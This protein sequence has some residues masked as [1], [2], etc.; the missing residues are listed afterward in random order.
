MSKNKLKF[1]QKDSETNLKFKNMEIEIGTITGV[2]K[3]LIFNN[4]CQEAQALGEI[5]FEINCSMYLV[6]PTYE[7]EDFN[8]IDLKDKDKDFVAIDD[9]TVSSCGTLSSPNTIYNLDSDISSTTTCIT[10]TGTNITFNGNGHTIGFASSGSSSSRGVTSAVS[11]TT[12]YNLTI[13]GL[14]TNDGDALTTSTRA[15]V[16]DVNIIGWSEVS[17]T[18]SGSYGRFENINITDGSRY[19]IFTGGNFENYINVSIINQTQI[20]ILY[21][22]DYSTFDNLFTQVRTGTTSVQISNSLGNAIKN[23]NITTTEGIAG[24]NG[25][26]TFGSRDMIITNT[27][28]DARTNALV[29]DRG[30][31]GI[32]STNN[33]V[34][35]SVLHNRLRQTGVGSTENTLINT[36]FP[37]DSISGVLYVK[38]WADIQVDTQCGNFERNNVWAFTEYTSSQLIVDPF[39]LDPIRWNVSGDARIN[40]FE[41]RFSNVSGPGFPRT[42]G[43]IIPAVPLNFNSGEYYEM[44]FEIEVFF[45]NVSLD[46]SICGN[47]FSYFAI[48]SGAKNINFT[49]LNSDGINMSSA[50]DSIGQFGSYA[51]AFLDPM[52]LFRIDSILAEN[53]SVDENGHIR[54][55]LEDYRFNGAT[56]S[57]AGNSTIYAN[58]TLFVS[59]DMSTNVEHTFDITSNSCCYSGTGN[60]EIDNGD[61]CSIKENV[62][63]N[64]NLTNYGVGNIWLDSALNRSLDIY[65]IR[66]IKNASDFGSYYFGRNFKFK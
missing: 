64:G 20:S 11:D 30:G 35:D 9:I 7:W 59:K 65:Q 44:S 29:F 5:D 21:T 23:S 25:L 41:A 57:Q 66:L 62:T 17:I 48:D 42:A 14:G 33:T 61:M 15:Y 1:K 36:T 46:I 51:V 8:N 37:D 45:T 58:D 19:G 47:D 49:C 54:L 56:I 13:N 18:P 43:S 52:F 55:P 50:N 39:F 3:E 2:K 12:I 24:T 10:I 40:F 27:H 31:T 4:T 26:K 34:I 16:Y 53:S 32:R 38:N 28:M 6:S 22:G 63:I 60:W